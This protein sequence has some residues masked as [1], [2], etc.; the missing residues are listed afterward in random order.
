LQLKQSFGVF[1]RHQKVSHK[2]SL[3][4]L[5]LQGLRAPGA[6]DK[7]SVFSGLMPY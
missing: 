4:C 7:P 3:V 1:L 5:G 6:V 2:I